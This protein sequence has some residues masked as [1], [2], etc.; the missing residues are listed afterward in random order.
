[1]NRGS[2][3]EQRGPQDEIEERFEL[4]VRS[5]KDYAIF[6]LDPRGCVVSWN[7]GAERIKGYPANEILGKSFTTFYPKEA[8]DSGFPQLELDVAS[9]EGRFEDEG[10]RVRKDGSRFW[11]NVVI[12]ALR[13]P[14]GQLVGFAKVTRDLTARRE[15][16]AQARRLAVEQA[17]HAEAAARS[18]ELAQ[19]N[20]RLRKQAAE[21]QVALADTKALA[22]PPSARPRLPPKH[23]GS[24]ISSLTLLRTT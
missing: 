18:E 24:S 17:A 2:L 16:E 8:V 6:M 19:L 22:T 10:W 1:M 23:I 15:A 12:T 7:E 21:L 14:D 3:V 4:L 13:S 9:R 20:D 5:V 11:A